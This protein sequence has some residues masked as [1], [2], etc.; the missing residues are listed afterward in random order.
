MF[1]SRT[2]DHLIEPTCLYIFFKLLVPQRVEMIA[3]LSCQLPRLISR[4]PLDGFS[5][6]SNTTHDW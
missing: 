3:E 1:L 5:N 2:S 4:Q 6:L